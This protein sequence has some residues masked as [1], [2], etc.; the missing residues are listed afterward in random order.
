MIKW[1]VNS[2]S[3]TNLL[4]SSDKLS[5]VSGTFLMILSSSVNVR[6]NHESLEVLR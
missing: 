4:R 6:V 3:G 5:R 1:L 2:P